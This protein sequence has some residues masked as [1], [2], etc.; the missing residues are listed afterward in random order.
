MIAHFHPNIGTCF[1]LLEILKF[2]NKSL[3][4]FTLAVL[5]DM[6]NLLLMQILTAKSMQRIQYKQSFN[7]FV[8]EPTREIIDGNFQ[9]TCRLT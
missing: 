1:L 6:V 7:T 5:Y 3:K 2:E 4:L 9:W 8:D